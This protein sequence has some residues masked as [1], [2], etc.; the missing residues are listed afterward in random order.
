[1]AIVTKFSTEYKK[2]F[3][4]YVS[5]LFYLAKKGDSTV[6]ERIQKVDDLTE[7]YFNHVGKHADW[8]Q[9]ERLGYLILYDDMADTDRMKARNSEY[10]VLSD[11]QLRRR[12]VELVSFVL[13]AEVGIDGRDHRPK[14][15][16]SMRKFREMCGYY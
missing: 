9:L 13:A 3:S 2:Q 12:E 10:P 1:M 16:D 4:E 7:A 6:T 8:Y 11:D 5:L 15:R 14:T